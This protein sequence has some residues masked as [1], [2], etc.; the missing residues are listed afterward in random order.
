MAL[1]LLNGP[2]GCGKGEAYKTIR[3]VHNAHDGRVK[4]RLYEIASA[5]FGVSQGLW[6]EREGKEAPHPKLAVSVA[7]IQALSKHINLDLHDDHSPQRPRWAGGDRFLLSPRQALIYASEALIKPAFGAGY[8]GRVRRESMINP[9]ETLYVDDSAGFPEELEGLNPRDVLILHIFGRGAFSPEDTRRYIE[10]PGAT[11]IAINNTGTL[12]QYLF[13][14]CGVVDLWLVGA[15][16][17]KAAPSTLREN[18]N[19]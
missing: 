19:D 1:I 7:Q 16:T 14:V 5:V 10:L 13:E 4:K 12:E 11:H 18:Q 9:E 8:F 3:A 2:A 17:G 15:F 6:E